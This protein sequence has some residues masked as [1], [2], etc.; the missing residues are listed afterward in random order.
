MQTKRGRLGFVFSFVPKEEKK[1]K[2]RMS[3]YTNSGRNV[4]LTKILTNTDAPVG[5]SIMVV[6]EMPNIV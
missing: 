1:V 6:E 2:G 4:L 5:S 3:H